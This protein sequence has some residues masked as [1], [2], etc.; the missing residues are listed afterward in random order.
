MSKKLKDWV[1][2]EDFAYKMCGE[3]ALRPNQ[4]ETD[5]DYFHQ[6]DKPSLFIAGMLVRK[7]PNTWKV[8]YGL[9]NWVITRGVPED[10]KNSL[11]NAC[12]E[13]LSKKELSTAIHTSQILKNKYKKEM[14]HKHVVAAGYHVLRMKFK[15]MR[16]ANHKLKDNSFEIYSNNCY[17]GIENLEKYLILCG[18]RTPGVTLMNEIRKL[19]S[20]EEWEA[21]I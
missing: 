21:G 18:D 6:V 13:K 20:F 19:I 10:V 2:D 14:I 3:P 16:T 9:L 7:D 15:G 12:D 17:L 5:S 4:F 1:N 11:E 8:I